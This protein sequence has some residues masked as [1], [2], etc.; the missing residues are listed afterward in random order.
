MASVKHAELYHR[1]FAVYNAAKRQTQ[2]PLTVYFCRSAG[3]NDGAGVTKRGAK[4]FM[5]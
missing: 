4:R 3:R 5:L 1:F 2:S